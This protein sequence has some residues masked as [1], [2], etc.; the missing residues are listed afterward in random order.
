[1]S[2]PCGPGLTLQAVVTGPP[3][4]GCSSLVGRLV[5]HSFHVSS[6][7][8]CWPRHSVLLDIGCQEV[9]LGVW[10]VGEELEEAASQAD[11]FLL[12]YRVGDR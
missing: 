8:T 3:G 5:T 4:A 2:P 10:D 7:L 12:C 11:V 1:M 9:T 6:S